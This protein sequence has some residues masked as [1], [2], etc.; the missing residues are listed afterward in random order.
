M[1][2]A[3]DLRSRVAFIWT[4]R[5]LRNVGFSSTVEE[6][7]NSALPVQSMSGLQS[8][9]AATTTARAIL[10]RGLLRCIHTC[11]VYSREACQ[12]QDKL[13]V[14]KAV[15]QTSNV[16][17]FLPKTK[18]ASGIACINRCSSMPLMSDVSTHNR[19]GNQ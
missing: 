9:T 18:K 11:A 5:E 1:I 19:D 6:L 16:S 17:W 3:S 4:T 7:T 13:D 15:F 2:E 14:W 8:R 10:A 12:T